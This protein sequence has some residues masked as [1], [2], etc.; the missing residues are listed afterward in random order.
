MI[1]AGRNVVQIY[2]GGPNGGH[3]ELRRRDNVTAIDYHFSLPY[4][5]DNRGN[6]MHYNVVKRDTTDDEGYETK[7]SHNYVYSHADET[8]CTLN[9]SC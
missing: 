5:L 7:F 4:I 9:P 3:D 2:H 1:V 6:P 8:I